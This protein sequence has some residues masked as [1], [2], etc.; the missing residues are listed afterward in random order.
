MGTFMVAAFYPYI[1][2]VVA[3]YSVAV[4]LK[5]W[6]GPRRR[7]AQ[8]FALLLFSAAWW[9]FGRG[10]ESLTPDLA[11]KIFW[12]KFQYFGI[13]TLPTFWLLFSLDYT[14][15]LD[16]INRWLFASLWLIPLA[17]LALVLTNER[18][19]LIW[20]IVQPGSVAWGD[21]AFVH[22][23]WFWI[24]T[25][26]GYLLVAAGMFLLVRAAFT[27]PGILRAQ[28]FI[29]AAGALAPLVCNLLYL[30]GV[31]ALDLTPVGF[32]LTGV[33]YGWNILRYQ[34]LDL[35]PAARAQVMDDLRDAVLILD[36]QNRIVDL[37]ASGRALLGLDPRQDVAGSGLAQ[38][39]PLWAAVLD[40]TPQERWHG[41]V[42]LPD[43][44]E[45]QSSFDISVSPLHNRRSK[46][47]GRLVVIHNISA[48]KAAERG[49]LESEARFR[50]L[51]ETAPAAIILTNTEGRIVRA[52]RRASELFGYGPDELAGQPIRKLIPGYPAAIHEDLQDGDFSQTTR[53]S[54]ASHE[55]TGRNQDGSEIDLALSYSPLITTDGIIYTN[56][57]HDITPLRRSEEQLRLQGA[58]LNAAANGIV[59][60]D[61]EGVILWVNAAF[62]DIT[63]YLPHEVMGKTPNILASGVHGP[64]F[65]RDLWDTI[66]AG[67]IW[68]GEITNRRKGG[69]LYVEFQTISPVLDER[70]GVSNY[71]AIKQ[72]VTDQKRT[73]LEIT[74][75]ARELAVINE[76]GQAAASNLHLTTLLNLVGDKIRQ[77]F[78]AWMVYIALLDEETNLIEFPYCVVNGEPISQP[79]P[80]APG[81]GLTSVVMREAK[82]LLID[83]D[84]AETA[85][86]LGAVL[87]SNGTDT[88]PKTWIGVPILAGELVIGVLSVQDA[89]REHA[90]SK[91]DLNLLTTIAANLGVAIQN[92]RLYQNERERRAV[93]ETLQRV[94]A[95]ITASL[96]RK[97]VLSV[98]L[99]QLRQV[100]E[101][102]SASIMQW[103]EDHSLR[104]VAH[105]GFQSQTQAEFV[106]TPQS[107]PNVWEVISKRR[108]IVVP[109]TRNHSGW[110]GLAGAT[111]HVRSWI[112]IPLLYKGEVMGI[113]NIDS[114]IPNFYTE[115]NIRIASIFADQAA[116]AIENA[117]LY[118]KAQFEL[119]FRKQTEE[120]LREANRSML[121]QVREITALQE[122]LQEQAL[123]DP[124]TGLYNRRFLNESLPREIARAD[125]D[126]APL[127]VIM[128]DLDHFKL[129]NDAYGHIKGD[130]ALVALGELLNAKTRTSDIACRYGGEEFCLILPGATATAVAERAEE[131]RAAFEQIEV[132]AD[133]ATFHVTIS[134][135]ASIFPLHGSTSE[136]LLTRADQA[137]YDAK[138]AGR[139]RVVISS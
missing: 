26:Y 116:I 125:R 54:A 75:R 122:Q 102:D 133:D 65:F 74:Q 99:E 56:V 9:A 19:G 86:R 123:R 76:I 53:P 37:N 46:P 124:V 49:V 42:A 18:H 16:R 127:G 98:I 34:F 23:P 87:N 112:G 106:P 59:V 12:T 84:Y 105:I 78:D 36:L 72:D 93:A 24:G 137:L 28:S 31:T 32:G 33:V 107:A 64:E 40:R 101:Y 130:R 5:A 96:E 11:S 1:L 109:D 69:D 82:P 79:E 117:R 68:R 100:V 30:A 136:E 108:S 29:L 17:S 70:G 4:G 135:G 120:S 118:G 58:A 27:L 25:A 14:Q 119:A 6:R 13:A 89:T 113:L 10:M 41:E 55:L 61:T 115:R 2:L 60:T 111:D 35:V 20:T 97:E 114:G 38:V 8:Y 121:Q 63:G 92:A 73:E 71:I 95:A 134:L 21:L 50:M 85:D 110:V 129:I 139:N 83:E 3:L 103:D 132:Q 51:V 62:S 104:V 44:E 126:G 39:A 77:K 45:P 94:S 88:R 47:T 81:Q 138:Q 90:Y 7:G 128:M 91:D 57:V 48:R 67:R 43:A 80:L 131:L 22:G 52:N 66:R 15:R